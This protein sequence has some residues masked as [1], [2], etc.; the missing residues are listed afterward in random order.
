MAAQWDFLPS[1]L[2]FFG[3]WDMS[4]ICFL[5]PAREREIF[6]WI[7]YLLQFFLSACSKKA[8]EQTIKVGDEEQNRRSAMDLLNWW[9]SWQVYMNAIHVPWFLNPVLYVEMFLVFH[10]PSFGF[11]FP[12]LNWLILR[13]PF[14]LAE[15]FLNNATSFFDTQFSPQFS[16]NYF[17]VRCFLKGFITYH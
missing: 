11:N 15:G 2:F 3:G 16:L 10:H 13:S 7:W 5:C 17:K 12:I 1:F 14:A 6:H 9:K 8:G 4:F